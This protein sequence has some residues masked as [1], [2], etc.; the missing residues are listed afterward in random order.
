MID[1]YRQPDTPLTEL[2]ARG[3][4]PDLSPGLALFGQFV[5]T[6]TMRVRFFDTA[7]TTTFD[8]PGRWSFGW[9]LDGRSV[10]DVLTYPHGGRDEYGARGIGT[11]LR[12][13]YPTTNTWRVVWLG[14]H[15]GTLIVL[16]ARAVGDEIHLEGPDVDG[17]AL[18]WTF[19]DITSSRFHWHG[20]IADSDGTWRLEQEM[21]AS[22]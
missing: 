5:G 3:P 17:S 19:T 18:L 9:V 20:W 12:H 1:G 6:W 10:Q 13:Y 8:H 21:L 14:T 16:T 11:S 22:R 4:H 15:S 2:I 7:G